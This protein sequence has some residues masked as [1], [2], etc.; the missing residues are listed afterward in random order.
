[1]TYGNRWLHFPQA[2]LSFRAALDCLHARYRTV[3]IPD[4]RGSV[5]ARVYT[6]DP[7]AD[8]G[9]AACMNNSPVTFF[10]D[11]NPIVVSDGSGLGDTTIFVSTSKSRFV[12]VRVGAPDGSPLTRFYSTLPEN[13]GIVNTGKWVTNGMKFYLQDVSGGKKLD[14][15]NTLATLTVAVQ[16]ARR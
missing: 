14:A 15:R 4:S 5:Y 7:S 2:T 11:P 1:M 8:N 13:T 10:A 12:E 9:G 16:P 3:D 6:V